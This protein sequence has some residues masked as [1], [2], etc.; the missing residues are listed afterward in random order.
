MHYNI[1]ERWRKERI[2]PSGVYY[3][4]GEKCW[5]G[6]P[7]SDG[8]PQRQSALKLGLF[9]KHRWFAYCYSK[10]REEIPQTPPF[11]N[12]RH[13]F[14]R[15]FFSLYPVTHTNIVTVLYILCCFVTVLTALYLLTS[16]IHGLLHSLCSLVLWWKMSVFMALH[17]MS[18]WSMFF[19]GC[20]CQS[21]LQMG[22]VLLQLFGRLSLVADC[23]TWAVPVP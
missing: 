6:S 17:G 14:C 22:F 7:S 4:S 9:R 20:I 19:F 2:Q 1:H 16:Y 12:G 8:N 11:Y 10:I 13:H 18:F 5:L 23:S 21:N 3:R 15:F